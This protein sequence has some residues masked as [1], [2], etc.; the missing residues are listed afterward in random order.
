MQAFLPF[1][2]FAD[3]ARALDARRLGKQRVETIQVLRGLT[4]PGYGWRHHPAAA[5]WAAPP[6]TYRPGSAIRRCTAATDPRWCAR[7][8]GTTARCSE[9]SPTTCPT[10]SQPRTA[11]AAS[12]TVSLDLNYPGSSSDLYRRIG[13]YAS[14]VFAGVSLSCVTDVGHHDG[15][16]GKYRSSR[17]LS[18]CR[19]NSASLKSRCIDGGARLESMPGNDPGRPAPSTPRS[20]ASSE[21][22]PTYTEPTR[23]RIL[24][25]RFSQRSSTAPRRNDRLHRCTWRS[26]RGRVH[27]PYLAGSNPG[28]PHLP[29]LP[30]RQDPPALRS[31][32]PR[33]TA[34]RGPA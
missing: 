22:L 9:T 34:D 4:V 29:G 25:L 15:G 8:P 32:D 2:G 1:P 12:A 21:K 23:F 16:L 18:L 6:A 14:S 10:S 31:R 26:I 28:V 30:S 7:T 11:R 3:S 19:A 20:A 13:S 24:R 17:R 33:R 5:M 27:L